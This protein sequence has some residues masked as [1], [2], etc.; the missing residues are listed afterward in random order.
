MA[1]GGVTP[2]VHGY[3]DRRMSEILGKRGSLAPMSAG[4]IGVVL[5]ALCAGLLWAWTRSAKEEPEASGPLSTP[6]RWT[7]V[8]RVEGDDAIFAHSALE[9][10][11]GGET[12][13]VD[14]MRLVPSATHFYAGEWTPE[15][16][17]DLSGGVLIRVDV[18]RAAGVAENL[19][20]VLAI[21]RALPAEST[22]NMKLTLS[23]PKGQALTA[24]D[25]ATRP[26]HRQC[27]YC[28][29]SFEISE[30]ECPSCGAAV[31]A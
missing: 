31:G 26:G 30:L 22:A 10:G 3:F 20:D 29:H 1:A 15:V 13:I 21:L 8:I 16:R 18:S 2:Q 11:A 6:G 23:D 19:G 17:C 9:R 27:R 4:L 12:G 25:D 7:L 5:S 28:R 14:F 24:A